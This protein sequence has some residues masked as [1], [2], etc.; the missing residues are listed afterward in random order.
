VPAAI[1][2]RGFGTLPDKEGQKGRKGQA[3]SD[4]TY[5]T[6]PSRP[7]ERCAK[8]GSDCFGN[9][10]LYKVQTNKLTNKLS[11]VYIRLRP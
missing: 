5:P 2:C 10:N 11:A 1:S 3:F 8:F 9:V 7:R 6:V 4:H